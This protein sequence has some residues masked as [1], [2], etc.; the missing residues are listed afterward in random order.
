MEYTPYAP[1]MS[2]SDFD[3]PVF[4]CDFHFYEEA[5][6]FTRYLPEQ[7]HGLVRIADVDGRRKMIIR[8]RVSDYIPN[9]TFEVVAEP[10]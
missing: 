9:P 2:F 3:H 5:D 7:Y 6:S 8:G 1:D 10:G 4:D